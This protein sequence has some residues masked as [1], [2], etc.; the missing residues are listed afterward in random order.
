VDQ[1]IAAVTEVATA[2]A[3]ETVGAT[4]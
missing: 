1:V 3:S 4:A 2:L